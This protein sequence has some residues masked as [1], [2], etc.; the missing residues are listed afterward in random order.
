MPTQVPQ[1]ATVTLT[2]AQIKA[3]PTTPIVIVPPTETINY[4]GRPTK[5]PVTLFALFDVQC[6]A[7]A[8][9]NIDAAGSVGLA[10][11]SDFSTEQTLRVKASD[12][13]GV[14]HAAWGFSP[15]ADR[16]G[17]ETGTVVTS[18]GAIYAGEG[19]MLDNGIA[20]GAL[21][22]SAGNFTGGHA[23]NTMKVTVVYIVV[24]V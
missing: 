6:S 13:L 15:A 22:G 9:T 1:T 21:N 23:N 2:D 14:A 8:Y 7:G 16:V 17:V 19:L 24:D 10:W 3:L 11:G 12:F 20:I 5:V 18:F 4:E